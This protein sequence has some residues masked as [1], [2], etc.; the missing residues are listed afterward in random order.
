MHYPSFALTKFKSFLEKRFKDKVSVEILYINHDFVCFLDEQMYMNFD[1]MLKPGKTGL[2]IEHNTHS[3][4]DWFFKSL[5]FEEESDNLCDYFSE[6]PPNKEF[7]AFIYQKRKEVVPFLDHLIDQ[8][9]IGG[10]DIVG[11]TSM[12]EQHFASIAMSRAIK[13]KYPQVTTIIG[14]PNC[15]YPAADFICRHIDSFDYVISGDGL[16]ALE[17]IAISFLEN[18]LEEISQIP[19]IFSGRAMMEGETITNPIPI[20]EEDDLNALDNL[21]YTLFFDSIVKH[22]LENH[23]KPVLFFETSKGCWWQEKKGCYFCGINCENSRYQ[24]ME[25]S[26]AINYLQN[27]FSYHERC[28]VFWATDSVIPL[29]YLDDVFPFLKIPKNIKIFYEVRADMDHSAIPKLAHYNIQYVQLG[30]EALSTDMLDMMN[31]GTTMFDN[32]ITLKLCLENQI[33]VLWNLLSGIP[34]ME[35]IYYRDCLELIPKLYHMPPPSGLWS[36]SFQKNSQYVQKAAKFSLNLKPITTLYEKLYSYPNEILGKFAYYFEDQ[37]KRQTYTYKNIKLIIEINLLIRDW[38]KK[39]LT[40]PSTFP[41]LY[42]ANEKIVIDTRTDKVKEYPITA[43]EYELLYYLKCV[44]TLD[45]I[46]TQGLCSYLEAFLDRGFIF[47]EHG[48]YLSL[49]FLSEPHY[50]QPFIP[51]NLHALI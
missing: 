15:I 23:I 5:A 28:S 14:G 47:E 31:K 33:S 13:K 27:L 24:T 10:A 8:Y 1:I 4:L 43:K 30:V 11:F 22:G 6:L 29:H 17:Q 3:I 40:E 42:I 45:E 19:G 46:Y 36:V 25:T 18:K 37:N 32:L 51:E 16:N 34:G 44:R 50:T 38:K 2:E 7:E 26:I 39:W 49:V 35:T 21:D 12:F 48:Q 20:A 41:K 9:Q